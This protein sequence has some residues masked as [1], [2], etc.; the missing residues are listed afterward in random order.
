M[1]N[2]KQEG[3]MSSHNGSIFSWTASLLVDMSK[4]PHIN[5]PSRLHVHQTV[6]VA[7]CYRLLHLSQVRISL[8]F[9]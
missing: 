2:N 6:K 7:L 9:H 4:H 3:P 8:S 1:S 5:V